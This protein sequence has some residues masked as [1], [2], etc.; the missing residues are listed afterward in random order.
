[1]VQTSPEAREEE[2]EQAL[3]IHEWWYCHPCER[4]N[5]WSDVDVASHRRVLRS[6]LDAWPPREEGNMNVG[7]VRVLLGR[8]HAPLP[9][10]VSVVA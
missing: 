2:R 9:L 5:S 8:A 10:L 7:L 4:E 3:A 1:M 6:G